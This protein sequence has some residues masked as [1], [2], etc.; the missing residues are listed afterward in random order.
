MAFVAF[1]SAVFV[2][3]VWMAGISWV[4]YQIA[5]ASKVYGLQRH[6]F[7]LGRLLN[8]PWEM[9]AWIISGVFFGVVSFVS[10]LLSFVLL[11]ILVMIVGVGVG[12]LLLTDLQQTH[13]R[14][15]VQLYTGRPKPANMAILPPAAPPP[16]AWLIPLNGV[17]ANQ[18]FTITHHSVSIGR[19]EDNFVILPDSTVSRHPACIRFAEGRW[20]IQNTRSRSGIYL[21]NRPVEAAEI[22]HL[23]QIQLGDV[24]L[25][26]RTTPR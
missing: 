6:S 15:P 22:A 18:V 20:F 14:E 13:G 1:I 23:D 25:E 16:T 19:S 9:P 12:V 10:A 3:G 7:A 4:D 24:Q 26:F 21:N 2:A 17:Q 5:Q 8:M 11:V